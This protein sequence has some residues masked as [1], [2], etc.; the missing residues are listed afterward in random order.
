MTHAYDDADANG[1]P[2]GL[3]NTV[4]ASS[5][6]GELVVTLRHVPALGDSPV[7]S[8]ELAATVRDNGFSAIGG[9]TDAQVTFPVQVP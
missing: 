4:V 1:L 7:K 9:T 8:A 6:G 2:I 5:G 3:L